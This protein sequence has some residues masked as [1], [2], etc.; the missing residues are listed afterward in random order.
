MPHPLRVSNVKMNRSAQVDLPTSAASPPIAATTVQPADFPVS[1][2]PL[3]LLHPRP[4]HRCCRCQPPR[5]LC[6][7]GSYS[8]LFHHRRRCC[9]SFPALATATVAATAAGTSCHRRSACSVALLRRLRY[10]VNVVVVGTETY[11]RP[12]CYANN[13]T[14]FL[15]NETYNETDCTQ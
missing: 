9:C 15:T 11:R 4:G 13:E 8:F 1:L 5:A 14:V 12:C 10:V 7:H 6:K 2:P 3:L